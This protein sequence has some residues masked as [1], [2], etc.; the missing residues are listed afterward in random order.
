MTVQGKSRVQWG[1][2]DSTEKEQDTVGIELTVQGK[3][4]IQWG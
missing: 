2:V 3:S 4:R 1:G